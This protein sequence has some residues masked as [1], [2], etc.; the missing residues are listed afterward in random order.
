MIHYEAYRNKKDASRRELYL[1]T[2]RDRTTLITVLKE[3]LNP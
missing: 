1:K 2:S 3:F